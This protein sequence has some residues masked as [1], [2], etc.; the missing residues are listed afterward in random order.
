MEHRENLLD[1]VSWA[2]GGSSSEETGGS[3]AERTGG[4]IGEDSEDNTRHLTCGNS[5]DPESGQNKDAHA[6]EL[7]QS[8]KVENAG[9]TGS[10]E[11]H[12]VCALIEIIS[13]LFARQKE[14]NLM[15]IRFMFLIGLQT[16]MLT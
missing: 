15:I 10:K 1:F 14:T 11:E 6:M 13:P 2:T 8:G 9:E 12:Q 4:S 5:D 3:P 16:P 7:N